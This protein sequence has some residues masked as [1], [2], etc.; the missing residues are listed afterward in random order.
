VRRPS[1]GT[2]VSLGRGV[3]GRLGS[4]LTMAAIGNHRSGTTAHMTKGLALDGGLGPDSGS[5][6]AR[7]LGMARS[8]GLAS[9]LRQVR[10]SKVELKG[11]WV[12]TNLLDRSV[13][14]APTSQLDLELAL[15]VGS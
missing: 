4:W 7:K 14:R 11:V 12:I 3:M 9:G 15:I 5:M 1:R 10:V 13:M 8:I 2:E 6:I